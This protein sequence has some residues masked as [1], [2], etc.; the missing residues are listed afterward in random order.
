MWCDT[1]SQ[2]EWVSYVPARD[3]CTLL[4]G[5]TVPPYCGFAPTKCVFWRS[6]FSSHHGLLNDTKCSFMVPSLSFSNSQCGYDNATQ[7]GGVFSWWAF[8]TF[9][10]CTKWSKVKLMLVFWTEATRFLF[11]LKL[12][13][14]FKYNEW[15]EDYSFYLF[16][17]YPGY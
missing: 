16:K 14:S 11:Y 7:C 13:I 4:L 9:L 15:T 1:L 2:S 6:F 3:G 12:G 8:V 5:A 17:K 10:Y